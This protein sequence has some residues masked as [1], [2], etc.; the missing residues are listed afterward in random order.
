MGNNDLKT[1]KVKFVLTVK[2]I[3]DGD[4]LQKCL[5]YAPETMFSVEVE[6][7]EEDV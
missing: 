4:A 7:V 3:C 2:A 1:Y 6:E 5:K